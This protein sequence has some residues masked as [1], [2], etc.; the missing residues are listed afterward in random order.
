[1]P[2]G[3]LRGAPSRVLSPEQ[4][5]GENGAGAFI[6]PEK[7][8][9]LSALDRAALSTDFL[10]QSSPPRRRKAAARTAWPANRVLA[11]AVQ[12]APALAPKP[13]TFSSA[14]KV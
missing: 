1:M 6:T 3:S 10:T 7:T 9:R 8:F 12:R 13:D 11:G 5:A 4:L 2:K 14:L